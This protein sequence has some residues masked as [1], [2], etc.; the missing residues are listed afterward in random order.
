MNNMYINIDV[1]KD[2]EKFAGKNTAAVQLDPAQCT[3]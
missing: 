2:S 1:N 3:C